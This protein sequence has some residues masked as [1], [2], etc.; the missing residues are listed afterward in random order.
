MFLSHVL[1]LEDIIVIKSAGNIQGYFF[2][3]CL[4]LDL[5]DQSYQLL[6]TTTVLG[7]SSANSVC[8]PISRS[9]TKK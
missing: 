2:K 4:E 3:Q 5:Y 9:T 6:T 1:I 8:R 7:L